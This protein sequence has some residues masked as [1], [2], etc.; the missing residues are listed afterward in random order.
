MWVP[1]A[2][3]PP[4]SYRQLAPEDTGLAG[5]RAVLSYSTEWL[6]DLRILTDP[7]EESAD[8]IRCVVQLC[9]E[10]AWHDFE[11]HGLQPQ[12]SER[13]TASVGLVFAV[14]WSV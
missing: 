11:R 10:G 13:L 1:V 6:L 5:L 3:P 4:P 2:P 9:D 8:K 7:Y 12:I 14:Q